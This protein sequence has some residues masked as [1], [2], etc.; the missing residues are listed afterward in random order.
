M[1]KWAREG[2]EMWGRE[3]MGIWR[4]IETTDLASSPHWNQRGLDILEL[5]E[6]NR[7]FYCTV[8]SLEHCS[9]MLTVMPQGVRPS[10]TPSVQ[11]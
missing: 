6:E 11:T 10:D 3:D 1:G 9:F 8:Q 7:K 4:Q 5:Q 2:V